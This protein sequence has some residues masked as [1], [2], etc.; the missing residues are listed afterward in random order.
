MATLQ[1][2]DDI[3][4]DCAIEQLEYCASLIDEPIYIAHYIDG[5]VIAVYDVEAL[6]WV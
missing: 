5:I 1:Q 3:I 4:I 2:I 6:G